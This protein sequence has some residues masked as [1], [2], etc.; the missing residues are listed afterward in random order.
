MVQSL[1]NHVGIWVH[2][3][4]ALSSTFK[5]HPIEA[6]GTCGYG[7]AVAVGNM[8][9]GNGSFTIAGVRTK[10]RLPRRSSL[11]WHVCTGRI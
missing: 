4:R 1:T 5:K 2:R 3:T 7:A 9:G 11:H 10:V 6:D 8:A